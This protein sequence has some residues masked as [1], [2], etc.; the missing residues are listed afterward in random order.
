[1]NDKN[2][3]YIDVFPHCLIRSS[4]PH[5]AT[6]TSNLSGDIQKGQRGKLGSRRLLEAKRGWRSDCVRVG[7]TAEIMIVF[8]SAPL[9]RCGALSASLTRTKRA[10]LQRSRH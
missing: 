2:Y 1:M 3:D 10:R 8:D 6:G 4:K 7:S 5:K 9:T